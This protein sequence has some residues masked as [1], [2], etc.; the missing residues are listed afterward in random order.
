MRKRCT[1]K[2]QKTTEFASHVSAKVCA[3][4]VWQFFSAGFCVFRGFC[5]RPPHAE[6]RRLCETLRLCVR[7]K[8][9]FGKCGMPAMGIRGAAVATLAARI[10]ECAAAV[11]YARYFD[12]KMNLR[13]AD[14]FCRVNRL[15]AGDFLR[16][17]AP[18]MAGEIVWA[19]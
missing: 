12:Q 2:S 8:Y 14:F 16:Y 4:C 11:I 7:R 15:L 5:V 9:H 1:Q 17:G 18:I 10:V 3:V 6:P 13:L 19:I